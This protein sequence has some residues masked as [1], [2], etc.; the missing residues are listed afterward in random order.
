MVKNYLCY[1]TPNLRILVPNT[2]VHT[3]TTLRATRVRNGRIYVLRAGAMQL[4][5]HTLQLLKSSSLYR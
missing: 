4:E 5:N 2:Q 1:L 3:Q